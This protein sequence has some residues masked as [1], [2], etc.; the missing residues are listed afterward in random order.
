VSGLRAMKKDRTRQALSE[1]A[2]DLFLRHGFKAVSVADVAAAAEVSKPTLFRHFPSKED[3]VL[4]RFVDHQGEAARVVRGR[5]TGSP[6]DALHAHFRAGLDA[7]EPT[8]GLCDHP[9]VLA[10]YRL[11]YD[12]PSLAS[13]L[14]DYVADDTAALAAALGTGVVTR[15]VAAQIIAVLHVLARTNITTIAAGA[16]ADDVYPTAVAEADTAFALL[17]TGAA[18]HGF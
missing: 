12:T 7:H 18:S 9:D 4:Q 17:R 16:A 13:R 15:L 6:L 5:T 3:L 1:T 11:V 2:I 10:F 14:T 8:T